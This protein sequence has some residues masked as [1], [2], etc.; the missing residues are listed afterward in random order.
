MSMRLS[1]E[2]LV[3]SREGPLDLLWKI[4]ISE[5]LLILWD[6]KRLYLLSIT[7]KSYAHFLHVKSWNSEAVAVCRDGLFRDSVWHRARCHVMDMHAILANVIDMARCGGWTVLN[8][9]SRHAICR[10]FCFVY[11]IHFYW[12]KTKHIIDT[13]KIACL[14]HIIQMTD[15][16][17]IVH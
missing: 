6:L 17:I 14:S 15:I 16:L 8:F 9:G 1:D 5:V 3:I 13:I 10:Q 7:R 11:N 12:Q 4:I 2:K